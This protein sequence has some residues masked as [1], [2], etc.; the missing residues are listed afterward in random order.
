MSSC[1]KCQLTLIA[2][3]CDAVEHAPHISGLGD[4]I[5][6][7]EG[8]R[9]VVTNS[10]H[11][12]SFRWTKRRAVRGRFYGGRSRLERAHKRRPGERAP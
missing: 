12:G 4:G 10:A 3:V 11:E 7:R 8:G 5:S 6:V 1:L 9:V 2:D